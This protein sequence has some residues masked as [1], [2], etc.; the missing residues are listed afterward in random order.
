VALSRPKPGDHGSRVAEGK[1]ESLLAHAINVLLRPKAALH[2]HNHSALC[3]INC[4]NKQMRTRINFVHPVAITLYGLLLLI[5]STAAWWQFIYLSPKH[6][7]NDMLQNNLST[8]SVTKNQLSTGNQKTSLQRVNLQFGVQNAV[9]S[10]ATVRS[11]AGSATT[12]TIGMPNVA[13]VR[14]VNISDAQNSRNYSNVTNVWAKLAKD[15]SSA[16]PQL[17]TQTLLDVTAAPTLP[18][19]YIDPSQRADMLAYI[20]DESVFVPDYGHVTTTTINGRKSYVYP[21][22]VKLAPY[23][24]LMQQYAHIYG[25]KDLDKVSPSDYQSA[26]PVKLTVSVD[27]VSHEMVRVSLLS[28]GFNETYTDYGIAKD[29]TVPTKTI[30]ADELQKRLGAIK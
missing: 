20:R 24:R 10:L 27:R 11:D 16:L 13:Y 2:P 26:A 30:S 15:S 29:I 1:V 6:A 9:R 23:L 17:F 28:S 7:F 8:N 22:S 14:Y 4:Y 12:E 25:L 19:G 3:Q 21:V 5:A 18:V